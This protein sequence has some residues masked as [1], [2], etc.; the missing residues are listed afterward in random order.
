MGSRQYRF[1]FVDSFFPLS[2]IG[3]LGSR[4]LAKKKKKIN[5]RTTQNLVISESIV[6]ICWFLL[7]TEEGKS[8][9]SL[10]QLAPTV[11]IHVPILSPVLI[12][13]YRFVVTGLSLLHVASVH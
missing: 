8:C 13:L 6:H 3:K 7:L 12:V 9:T 11:Q 10:S 1:C 4:T 2:L 5:F